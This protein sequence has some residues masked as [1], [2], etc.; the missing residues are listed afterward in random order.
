MTYAQAVPKIKKN[1]K[2]DINMMR[3]GLYEIDKK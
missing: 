3:Y 1:V 2:A